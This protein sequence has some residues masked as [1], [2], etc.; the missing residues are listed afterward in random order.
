MDSFEAMAVAMAGGAILLAIVLVFVLPKLGGS[1]S[2]YIDP[3][4]DGGD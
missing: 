1:R 3:G 4:G 2:G